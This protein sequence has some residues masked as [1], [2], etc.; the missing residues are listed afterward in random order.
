MR[1]ISSAFAVSMMI[2]MSRVDGSDLRILQTSS[3][4]I[5]GNMRSRMMRA[6]ASSRALRNPATPS[7]RGGDIELARLAQ[8]QREQ[9]DHIRFVL[10]DQDFFAW[11]ATS[12]AKKCC[13]AREPNDGGR[14]RD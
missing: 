13:A 2:G 12:C 5:F 10:D 4:G 7:D 6:G 3:P 1:S 14:L 9:I 11:S 8:L